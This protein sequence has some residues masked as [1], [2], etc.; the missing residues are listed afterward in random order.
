MTELCMRQPARS[1]GTA[2]TSPET[3]GVRALILAKV[4]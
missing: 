3:K 2:D 4:N 1:I